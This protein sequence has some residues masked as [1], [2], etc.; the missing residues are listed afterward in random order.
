MKAFTHWS[1][2]FLLVP[3]IGTAI[4][5][6]APAMNLWLP[7]DVSVMGGEIDHL[8]YLIL[9]LTGVV[10]LL[11]QILLAF[12]VWFYDA[13]RRT[14]P[15]IYSHGNHSLE[16]FW[17]VIP[18]FILVF[19]GLYQIQ[20]WANLTMRPPEDPALEVEVTG[21]QFEWRIRYPGPDGEFDTPDDLYHVNDLHVPV[22]REVVVYLKS[23]DVLH[24]FFLPNLRLKQDIVPGMT[25]R[26]WFRAKEVGE[27]DLVCAELCGWGHYKMKGRLTI[28]SQENFQQWLKTMANEQEAVQ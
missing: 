6:A 23:E 10:F 22:N 15:A 25:G 2:F 5:V 14:E 3:L 9:W 11:T 13:R 26:V 7:K 27:F 4:F 18:A 12:F 21:R 24:S 19:L 1:L 16:L 20:A 28:Q 17:T 8:F